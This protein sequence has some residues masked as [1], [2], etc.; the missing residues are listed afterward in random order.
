MK[1]NVPRATLLAPLQQVIGVVEK[2]QTQ[3]IL[4]NILLRL[5][6][7]GIELTGTDTEIQLVARTQADT[8][9]TG[10][11]TAPARKLLDILRLL[12]ELSTVQ[13]E[14]KE[15]RFNIR[16]GGGRYSLATLPVDHYPAFDSGT[17]EFEAS[18]P[19]DTL[20]RALSKTLFA[21]AQ[22]DVRYY[23][24]GVLIDLEGAT[25][26]TV[27][28]DGHRL[29][30]YEEDMGTPFD[31]NR[32]AIIPRKGVLELARLLA[33]ADDTVTLRIA[34]NTI[35]VDLGDIRFSAKLIEGRYP[36]F[37]RV[38][39]NE[40][41]RSYTAERDELKGALTR[42]SVLSGEKLK[43][44][45]L[46]VGN[47]AAM[48]LKSHNPE[49]EDAEERLTI[50]MQGEG[51]AAGFNASYLLDAINNID[52]GRAKLSFPASANSCLV[53]DAEDSRFKFIVMPMRL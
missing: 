47:D 4:S 46:E 2:R 20:R 53:E 26:R 6:E 52:S 48:V 24:N 39:P 42:V 27:A 7:N 30:L 19:A 43:T 36:D 21:M 13:V 23:L 11:V 22:Q 31:G 14:C 29:A 50:E 9:T 40:L 28:S 49:Q 16:C 18:I 10:T 38:L 3:P 12:P 37:R 32:Q 1:F 5:D 41:N 45:S 25:L 51:V 44:I 33:E 17:Y 15:D 35:T 34:P 8:G